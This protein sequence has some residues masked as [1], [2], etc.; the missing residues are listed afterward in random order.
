[1]AVRWSACR[2]AGSVVRINVIIPEAEC[3]WLLGVWIVYVEQMGGYGRAVE[4]G[5]GGA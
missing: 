2:R 3:G 1:M 4:S 5:A